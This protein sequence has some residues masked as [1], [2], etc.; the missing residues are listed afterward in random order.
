MSILEKRYHDIQRAA[1]TQHFDANETLF[2]ERELTQLRAKLFEVVYPALL[3]RTFAP[4]ASDIAASAETYSYKVY[5]QVGRADHRG[6]DAVDQPNIDANATEVLGKVRPITAGYGWNFNE[7]REAVRTNVPLSEVKARAA[8]DI[9][10]RGIDE[11]LAYGAIKDPTGALPSVG[12]NGLINNPDVEGSGGA[13]TLPGTY[14]TTGMDPDDM[15]SDLHK[16]AVTVGQSTKQAFEADSILLPKTHY[17]LASG[18]PWNT[19]TGL[20][21]LSVF[22]A[23][24]PNIKSV[25]PWYL[26]D[27]VATAEGGDSGKPRALGYKKDPMVLEAVIPQEFEAFPPE[28]RNFRFNILC[29]ARC[30]GVKWYQPLAGV[31]MDFATS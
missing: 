3:A 9:I 25:S 6:Y 31:Y 13:N 5:K 21:V 14:W 16:L 23:N 10:E 7:L 12:M 29:H 20:S 22:L 27:A 11:T 18:T 15:I 24:H 17:D 2:L 4:K 30:G 26:L 8:R 28:M 19:V 1:L